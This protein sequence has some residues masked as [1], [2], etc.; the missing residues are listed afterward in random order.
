M[1]LEAVDGFPVL[2]AAGVGELARTDTDYVAVF[3]VEFGVDLGF[4]AG[5]HGED[6][7]EFGEGP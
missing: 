6:V 5:H 4:V 2:C 7:G 1:F 3:L